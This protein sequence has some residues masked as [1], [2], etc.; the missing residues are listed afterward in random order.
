[1]AWASKDSFRG[2]GASS[3]PYSKDLRAAMMAAISLGV[4][5]IIGSILWEDVF[6][7]GLDFLLDDP[8]PRQ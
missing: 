2:R 7:K 3:A 8:D 1:M 5:G 4:G 6:R